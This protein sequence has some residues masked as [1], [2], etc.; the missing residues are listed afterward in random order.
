MYPS[1]KEARELAQLCVTDRP[2]WCARIRE[3]AAKG[4]GSAATFARRF[5][6]SF[7]TAYRWFKAAG[8]T[9]RWPRGH[10][11]PVVGDEKDSR[12]AHDP[13]GTGRKSEL[14]G[15]EEPSTRE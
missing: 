3:E 8:V 11:A 10:P 2:A 15:K 4:H 14:R 9:T 1:T 12:R 13:L 6:V 5:G 7:Q